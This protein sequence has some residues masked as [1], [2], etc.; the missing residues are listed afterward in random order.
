MYNVMHL[1]VRMCD[2]LN[3]FQNRMQM[4]NNDLINSCKKTWVGVCG[5]LPKTFTLL[6]VTI[7]FSLQ[8]LRLNAKLLVIEHSTK[9]DLIYGTISL[10]A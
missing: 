6:G 8:S 4:I 1:L 2:V 10:L 5:P 7:N 9:L 3:G